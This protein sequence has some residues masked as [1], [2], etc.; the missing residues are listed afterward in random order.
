M[1]DE[2]YTWI[3]FGYHSDD[4]KPYARKP[5]IARCDDCCQYKVVEMRNYCDMCD[6]CSRKSEYVSDKTRLKMS[7]VRKSASS[8]GGFV[9]VRDAIC[10]NCGKKIEGKR[11][12]SHTNHFCNK[13][14][15]SEWRREHECGKNNNRW[16]GGLKS[17]AC[18]NC[19]KKVEKRQSNIRP[20][21]FCSHSCAGEWFSKQ[22]H[23]GRK[24]SATRQGI[25]ID[26]WDGYVRDGE[27]CHL[28]DAAC[29]ERCREK[30]DRLCFL[31][32]KTEEDNGRKLDVHH[33]DMN[34]DQGCGDHE[35]KLVPLCKSC[36]GKSHSKAWRPR[37]EYVLK[38]VW[39][40]Q[41]V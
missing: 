1:I 14:C 34:K 25:H 38:Y 41:K 2:Y 15:Q 26:D 36:H 3:F 11:L 21:N 37:I 4:L 22:E 27:Y 12:A 35:W 23:I 40:V 10:A 18:D 33:V 32:Y 28:F 39:N 16:K 6:V 8:P 20:H 30:Y 29:R 13:G 24:I 7:I 5:I 17:L 19:G 31:C 9:Y